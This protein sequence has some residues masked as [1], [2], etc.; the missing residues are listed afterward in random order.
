MTGKRFIAAL[1]A[2]LLPLTAAAENVVEILPTSAPLPAPVIESSIYAFEDLDPYYQYYDEYMTPALTQEEA[3]RLSDAQSRLDNGELPETSILNKT[4]DVRVS[5]ILLPAD[6][7]EGENWYLI[8]PGRRL[9]NTELLQIVDAF[10]SI[11]IRLSPDMLSWRNCMRGGGI[12][13]TRDLCG[14]EWERYSALGDQFVRSGLRPHTPFT[15]SVMDDGV[16]QVFLDELLF[17]GMER[18]TFYPAR[19]INDQE[20]L[21]LYAL[22]NPEPAVSP[23]EFTSYETLLRQEL[24]T[25]MG[26]PISALRIMNSDY[27]ETDD[28]KWGDSRVSYSAAF[29]ES[30]INS[31]SWN[32]QI[33]TTTGKLMLAA[34]DSDPAFFGDS[35]PRSDIILDPWEPRW[36]EIARAAVAALCADSRT[37][38]LHARALCETLLNSYTHCA[39]VRVLMSDGSVYI[40]LVSFLTSTVVSISYYDSLSI[41]LKD[42]YDINQY[43][44]RNER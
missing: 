1:C 22:E 41:A 6:Q 30:G 27:I 40:V 13:G 12:P 19:Q 28:H 36:A 17:N 25:R 9:A 15:A 16:G 20:L 18:F 24:H 11:G 42:N 23:E 39:E 29:N 34:L 38:I 8:L 14:D 21:Q 7:Y 10:Q 32:G 31:R 5:L 3:V 33:D 26:M 35:E 2:V 43:A 4:E 44:R 37:E